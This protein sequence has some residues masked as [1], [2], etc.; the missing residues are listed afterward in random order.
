MMLLLEEFVF[1][2]FCNSLKAGWFV[3]G[4]LMTFETKKVHQQEPKTTLTKEVDICL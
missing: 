2:S 1:T 4:F 3:V